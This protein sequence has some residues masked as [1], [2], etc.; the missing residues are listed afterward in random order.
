MRPWPNSLKG[1]DKAFLVWNRFAVPYRPSDSELDETAPAEFEGN[2]HDFE[3]FGCVVRAD[4]SAIRGFV[5][6]RALGL[7]A[8]V[9]IFR[10]SEHGVAGGTIF[11][12]LSLI[13]I[14]IQDAMTMI[15]RNTRRFTND[16]LENGITNPDGGIGEIQ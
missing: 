15:D 7:Q 13:N 12:R 11:S 1:G 8:K 9:E 3:H 14:L 5:A 2:L 4:V 16:G 6:A 10:V